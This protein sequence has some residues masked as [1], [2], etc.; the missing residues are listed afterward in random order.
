MK[1]IIYKC[2]HVTIQLL[3]LSKLHSDSK[4]KKKKIEA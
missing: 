3:N 4:S 1:N 2:Y